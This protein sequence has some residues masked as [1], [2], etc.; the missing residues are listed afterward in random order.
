MLRLI[1][2]MRSIERATTVYSAICVIVL[3]V[4][5]SLTTQNLTH[6]L[7][8]KLEP[9]L[10]DVVVRIGCSRGTDKSAPNP[11]NKRIDYQRRY[12][13]IGRI[14]VYIYRNPPG[15]PTMAS[16]NGFR[17]DFLKLASAPA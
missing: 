11:E 7:S 14:A 3:M 12:L 4:C 9:R 6:P 13:S 10:S 15:K 5:S 1:Q 16:R 17:A 2:D 8:S